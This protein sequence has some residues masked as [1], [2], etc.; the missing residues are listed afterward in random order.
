MK[1]KAEDRFEWAVEA[2]RA[3]KFRF[4]VALTE[5]LRCLSAERLPINWSDL[6]KRPAVARLC[7]PTTVFRI[8]SRLESMGI[9]R[10]VG[11]HS[12]HT[13][14]VL[15]APGDCADYLICKACGDIRDLPVD[16]PLSGVEAGIEA[17]TGYRTLFHELEVYGIC[18]ECQ[19]PPAATGGTKARSSKSAARKRA[20]AAE[21]G[22]CL[23]CNPIALSEI[24]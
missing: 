15:S 17:K 20:A 22:R 9:V 1:T 24:K 16:C 6:A 23:S 11:L 18:P 2:C 3:R 8:I 21:P 12:R 10:R 13:H 4:T 14:Y 5:V 7:D 19:N